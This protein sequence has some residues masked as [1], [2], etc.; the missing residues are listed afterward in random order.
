MEQEALIMALKTNGVAHGFVGRVGLANVDSTNY[1]TVGKLGNVGARLRNQFNRS[2]G[3]RMNRAILLAL[4]GAAV[5]GAS[6]AY[7]QKR[8]NHGFGTGS[9]SGTGSLVTVGGK[10]TIDTVTRQSG[11]TV[12]Q[13]LTDFDTRMAQ[14]SYPPAYPADKSG[15]IAGKIGSLL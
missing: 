6:K 15:H 2:H 10:R 3:T 8:I 14:K 9:E 1:A 11:V 12:A 13:D 7:S 4:T 5:G